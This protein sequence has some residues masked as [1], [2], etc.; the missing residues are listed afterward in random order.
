MSNMTNLKSIFIHLNKISVNTGDFIK[1]GQK[2]GEVGS[3]GKSTDLIYI[4]L[5]RLIQ[6]ILIQKSL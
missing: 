4:G 2:I 5:L 3:T 6:Y 1:K